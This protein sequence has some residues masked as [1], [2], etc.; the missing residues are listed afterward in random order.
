[1]SMRRDDRESLQEL[2]DQYGVATV[3][4]G[5]VKIVHREMDTDQDEE[6][7]NILSRAT[8]RIAKLEEEEHGDEDDD[9][10]DDDDDD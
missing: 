8:K 5:L 1:M 10:D 7:Y 6:V 3:L 2:F 4:A 9:D